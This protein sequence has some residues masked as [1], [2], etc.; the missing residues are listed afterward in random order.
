MPR[1]SPFEP[2][3]WSLVK[4][5]NGCWIWTGDSSK[6]Y[7]RIWRG[8]RR[9]AAHRVA[10]ELTVG[11]IPP[12]LNACHHCDNRICVRPDHIF[13]GTQKDNM[14]DWTKKGLNKAVASRSLFKTGDDHWLRQNTKKAKI[15]RQS[16]SDRRKLEWRETQRVAIR[17]SR[18]RI[19]GTRMAGS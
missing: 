2:Y 8:T 4:K 3:F 11:P 10:Y 7:G 18:G 5:T 19:M 9:Y 6:G 14:Q 17:D 16:I 15:A 13:L 1:W 12:G